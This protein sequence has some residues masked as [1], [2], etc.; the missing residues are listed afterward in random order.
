M[1][2]TTTAKQK[3]PDHIL[4][5]CPIYY[6]TGE[7]GLLLLD[8]DTNNGLLN[9]CLLKCPIPQIWKQHLKRK[10]NT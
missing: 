7:N 4:Y 6:I 2:L 9:Q 8:D 1:Q 10:K 5:H 3:A